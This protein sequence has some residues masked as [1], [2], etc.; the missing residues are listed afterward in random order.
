[1]AERTATKTEI[2]S[3]KKVIKLPPAIGDWTTY[4]PAKIMVKKVKTGLYGFDR[5]SREE[6]DQALRLHYQFIQ[7]LLKSLQIDLGLGVEF[8]ACQI[9]QTTYLNF[10]RQV[11]SPVVQGKQAI[12][13][14]HEGVH[15][16]FDLNVANSIINHALGSHDLDSLNRGLTEA[17]KEIFLT[18]LAEYL[19]KYS[20][21]FGNIFPTPALSFI[22]APELTPEAAIN[23]SATFVGFSAEVTLNDNPAGKVIFGYSGPVL[24]GL[25]KAAAEKAKAAP[26]NLGRLP[27]SILKKIAV[28]LSAKLGLTTLMTSELDRLEIGDV[29]SLDTAINAAALLQVGSEIKLSVQPGI[30]NK[31]K[32][33][34]L[35]RLADGPVDLP[36]PLEPEAEPIEPPATVEP[37]PLPAAAAEAELL[38]ETEEQEED[39][40][41]DDL[42]LED[43]DFSEENVKEE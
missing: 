17:E 6:L 26:L 43:E 12:H 3:Q 10:L 33:V 25:L 15:F 35:T 20:L 24:K 23:P 18:T 30:S 22:S 8:S 1:M 32:A 14:I 11:N 9:E 38:N 37:A 41:A 21:A 13:N 42:F 5:L 36:P 2:S 40:A 34:R 39:F 16:I 27:Q 29:V 7:N 4:R 28:R 19:P 31:K